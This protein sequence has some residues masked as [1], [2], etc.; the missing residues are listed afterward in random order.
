MPD[1]G[2][3]R[4]LFYLP[5]EI[6]T[7]KEVLADLVGED[8]SDYKARTIEA[9]TVLLD[10]LAT[11]SRQTPPRP[12]GM[13][14]LNTL[15]QQ[16]GTESLLNVIQ[17]TKPIDP[18]RFDTTYLA[19]MVQT[20]NHTLYVHISYPINRTSHLRATQQIRELPNHQS[21]LLSEIDSFLANPPALRKTGSLTLKSFTTLPVSANVLK[22][23]PLDPE[24]PQKIHGL[25]VRTSKS[26]P[27]GAR[28][29]LPRRASTTN[30]AT[31]PTRQDPH[32]KTMICLIRSRHQDE[33]PFHAIKWVAVPGSRWTLF[34][35]HLDH[36]DEK[37][38]AQWHT[39][40]YNVAPVIDELEPSLHQCDGTLV[41]MQDEHKNKIYYHSSC[42][43][44]HSASEEAKIEHPE[45]MLPLACLSRQELKEAVS[46]LKEGRVERYTGEEPHHSEHRRTPN[47]TSYNGF[48]PQSEIEI[49]TATED[50]L[51]AVSNFLR[52]FLPDYRLDHGLIPANSIRET[53]P[54]ELKIACD[55]KNAIV[56]LSN[57]TRRLHLH[58]RTDIGRKALNQLSPRLSPR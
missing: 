9:N 26:R 27:L 19:S 25:T 7:A 17:H 3:L 55:R 36:N 10:E 56:A 32:T 58:N 29:P 1:L 57:K 28:P 14:R 43:D 46:A 11:A 15:Q 34:K 54:G 47:A 16:V 38:R 23:A 52:A 31:P 21:F 5:E 6:K 53:Y 39:F 2:N 45:P 12:E 35:R 51:G 40:D 48:N 24:Q 50:D 20:K 30:L 8:H 13:F 33:E 22:T 37:L 18:L 49:R 41:I 42:T 44:K 4:T